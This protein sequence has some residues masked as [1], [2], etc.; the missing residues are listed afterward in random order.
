MFLPEARL[1][2]HVTGPPASPVLHVPPREP[3]NATRTRPADSGSAACSSPRTGYCDMYP[4][5]RLHQCYMFLP[6]DRL[7]RH[8]TGQPTPPVLHVPPGGPASAT[9]TRRASRDRMVGG[10]VV[11]G[12]RRLPAACDGRRRNVP[13]AA[14]VAGRD[15]VTGAVRASAPAGRDAG[16]MSQIAGRHQRAR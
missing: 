15:H 10:G 7:M 9:C 12:D 4:A 8:V 13:G 5:S 16:L 1:M 3:A 6:E 14:A 2:R 11:R